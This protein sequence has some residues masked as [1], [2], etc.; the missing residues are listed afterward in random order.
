M[1]TNKGD[2]VYEISMADLTSQFKVTDGDWDDPY[3]F[4]GSSDGIV[5]GTPYQLVDG[6]NTNLFFAGGDYITDVYI[7]VNLNTQMITVT[8]NYAEMEKVWYIQGVNG[9]WATWSTDNQFTKNE[10]SGCY[11]INEFAFTSAGEFKLATENWV[12]EY[13][14]GTDTQAIAFGNFSTQLY[15]SGGNVAYSILGTFGIRFNPE[16]E[17]VEFV[18]GGLGGVNEITVDLDNAADAIYYNLQGV[19]VSN[20]TNGVYIRQQNGSAVKVLVK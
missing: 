12:N 3:N 6:S 2:G 10:D 15:V 11:E 20:P 8:G 4:A 17:V 13:G 1:L 14:S 5:L 16:T 19:R 7:E 9:D 18:Q